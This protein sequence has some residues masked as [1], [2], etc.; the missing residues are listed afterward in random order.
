MARMQLQNGRNI[1]S[2][3]D[4]SDDTLVEVGYGIQALNDDDDDEECRET[5]PPPKEPIEVIDLT[6]DD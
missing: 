4:D 1:A 3:T 2:T 5:S 6:E